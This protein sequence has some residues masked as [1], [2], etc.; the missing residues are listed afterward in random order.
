M[1]MSL[2]NHNQFVQSKDGR[3]PFSMRYTMDDQF[4]CYI[5]PGFMALLRAIEERESHHISSIV[6]EIEALIREHKRV[7]FALDFEHPVTRHIDDFIVLELQDVLNRLNLHFYSV[8]TGSHL[9]D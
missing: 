9:G 8:N 6:Q 3:N 1:R 5:E 4:I 7:V 2:F